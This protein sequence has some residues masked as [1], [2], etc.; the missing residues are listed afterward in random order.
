MEGRGMTINIGDIIEVKKIEREYLYIREA[1]CL[2]RVL[3]INPTLRIEFIKTKERLAI[4]PETYGTHW[5]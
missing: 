3:E 4:P 1:W 5:R 2:A